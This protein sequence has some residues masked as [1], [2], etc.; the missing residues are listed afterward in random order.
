VDLLTSSNVASDISNDYVLGEGR[1]ITQH[2]NTMLTV[3][4]QQTQ[5][6]SDI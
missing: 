3:E 2:G 1:I 6:S 4:G 5:I